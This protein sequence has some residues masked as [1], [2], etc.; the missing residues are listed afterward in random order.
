MGCRR[1]TAKTR[2]KTAILSHF[3]VAGA[4]LSPVVVAQ[5]RLRRPF[6][7]CHRSNASGNGSPFERSVAIISNIVPTQSGMGYSPFL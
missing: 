5:L 7:V 6:Q 2:A 4:L 1:R 3:G